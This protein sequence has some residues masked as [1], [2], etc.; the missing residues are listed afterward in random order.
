MVPKFSLRIRSGGTAEIRRDIRDCLHLL[1][2]E[3]MFVC[4]SA[5]S[6]YPKKVLATLITTGQPYVC[7]L[8]VGG[9]TVTH[10]R[11]QAGL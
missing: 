9:Q 4:P 10:T 1:N 6:N 11:N 5:V 7:Q 3:R 2:N 8:L